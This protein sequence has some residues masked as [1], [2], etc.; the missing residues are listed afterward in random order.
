MTSTQLTLTLRF[1][2]YGSRS[3][4]GSNTSGAHQ[5]GPRSRTLL[6]FDCDDIALLSDRQTILHYYIH[7]TTYFV[8]CCPAVCSHSVS[9]NRV[10]Q[11][12]SAHLTVLLDT[13]KIF[14]IPP[15]CAPP[16]VQ[17]INHNTKSYYNSSRHAPA[18]AVPEYSPV[19]TFATRERLT[20]STQVQYRALHYC[21][22]YIQCPLKNH[23]SSQ[24]TSP[25]SKRTPV[26]RIP[27]SNL[28][29]PCKRLGGQYGW[30]RWTCAAFC[31][32]ASLRR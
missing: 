19:T 16:F 15:V 11:S 26:G 7:Y 25:G 23:P 13:D 31:A 4:A 5:Q 21:T 3:R 2:Q 6:L 22:E 32:M 1:T 17:G 9:S 20:Y 24:Q 18:D 12:C 28:P 8:Y 10:A 14:T 27:M 30:F 29:Q